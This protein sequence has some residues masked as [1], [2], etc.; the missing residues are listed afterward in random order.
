MHW[1]NVIIGVI[2]L[3]EIKWKVSSNAIIVIKKDNILNDHYDTKGGVNFVNR[4]L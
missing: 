1:L 3:F 4:V 2:L